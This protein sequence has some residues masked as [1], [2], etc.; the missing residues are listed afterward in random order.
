[1]MPNNIHIRGIIR[2]GKTLLADASMRS[3]LFANLVTMA[4][5]VHERW[6]LLEAV[7]L[8]WLQSIIIGFFSVLKILSLKDFSVE[9][10]TIGGEV[11]PT[12][13][14]TLRYAAG[15]FAVHFGLFHFVYSVFLFS[16]SVDSVRTH[17]SPLQVIISVAVPAVLFFANHLFSFLAHFES[18]RHG[19]NLGTMIFLPYVRIFPMHIIIMSAFLT[20]GRGLLFFLLLKT[21]ADAFSHD[22]EHSLKRKYA[23]L[24]LSIASAPETTE[25]Q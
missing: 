21:V 24:S 1:M 7:W 22:M 18:D 12:S 3:L 16:M 5:A 19:Q 15:F 2:S 8:Y 10:L 13:P 6:S 23:R 4:W 9:K 20:N 11:P 14:N 17:P 25:T